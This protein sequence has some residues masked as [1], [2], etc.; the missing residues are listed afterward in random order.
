M[1]GFYYPL[2]ALKLV[3]RSFL[4]LIRDTDSFLSYLSSL[5]FKRDYEVQGQ[6]KKRGICCHNVGI[7]ITPTISTSPILKSLII[8]WYRFV[9]NFS[10]N[11][12]K[13]YTL[14]FKCNYLINNKCSIH[15][16]RPYICRR[17]HGTSFFKKPSIIPGCGYKIVTKK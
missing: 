7:E 12:E 6:C 13:K 9:Y 3:L 10:F 14:L 15:W 2:Q 5:P 16:R 1:F 8:W 11:Q 4:R 17:Y